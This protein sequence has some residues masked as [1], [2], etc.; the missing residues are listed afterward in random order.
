LSLAVA[1]WIIATFAVHPNP[2]DTAESL[3]LIKQLSGVACPACGTTRATHALLLGH[4]S[5]SLMTNPL[6][7]VLLSFLVIV[8]IC[9]IHDAL[10]GRRWLDAVH[11]RIESTLKQS[12]ILIPLIILAVLNWAW[13]IFKGY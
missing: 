9:I 3:C 13:N 11:A 6:G 5:E 2:R 8:I 10:T 7:F 1:A 12:C 4:V